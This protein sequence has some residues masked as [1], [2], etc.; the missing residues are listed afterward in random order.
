[1]MQLPARNFANNRFL[2]ITL[3]I[4]QAPTRTK[5]EIVL[6]AHFFMYKKRSQDK[7]S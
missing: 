7:K 3:T 6:S 5:S 1:M 4:T 2:D